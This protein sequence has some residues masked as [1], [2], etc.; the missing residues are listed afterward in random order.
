MGESQ[1]NYSI[2]DLVETRC[3]EHLLKGYGY[4]R[5]DDRHEQGDYSYGGRNSKLTVLVAQAC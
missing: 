1:D 2:V 5:N 4:T 3:C